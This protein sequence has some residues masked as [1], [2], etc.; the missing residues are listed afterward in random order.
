MKS[1]NKCPYCNSDTAVCVERDQPENKKTS[2]EYFRVRCVN[3]KCVGNNIRCFFDT[4][5]EAVLAW[6]TRY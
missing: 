3:E 2:G 5:E 4:Y 6:D 1:P